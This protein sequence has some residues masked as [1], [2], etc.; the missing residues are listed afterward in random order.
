MDMGQGYIETKQELNVDREERCRAL[1]H[2][3]KLVGEL[4]RGCQPP[5][6]EEAC[7]LAC[8]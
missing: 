5:N 2:V 3:G 7:S 4:V 1:L 8:R 6:K